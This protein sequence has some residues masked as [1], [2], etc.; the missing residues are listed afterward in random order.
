MLFIIAIALGLFLYFRHKANII[1]QKNAVKSEALS[2]FNSMARVVNESLELIYNTKNVETLKSRVS[3]AESYLTQMAEIEAQ[4]Y[5]FS[6]KPS[7]YV[8]SNLH[9]VANERIEILIRKEFDDLTIKKDAYPS[10]KSAISAISKTMQKIITL[11]Q[12]LFTSGRNHD[13]IS[14]NID[15]IMVKLKT[16]IFE[17]KLKELI[18]KADKEELKGNIKKAKDFYLE[19]LHLFKTEGADVS[20]YTKELRL[21]EDKTN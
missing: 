16:F 21:I 20:K 9:N 14:C 13:S 2:A 4:G 8:L 5:T 17:G 18:E 1:L 10:V 19:A 7:S 15:S 12:S 11:R 6:D 3:V